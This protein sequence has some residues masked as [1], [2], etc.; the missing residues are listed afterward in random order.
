MLITIYCPLA[1]WNESNSSWVSF[2]FFLVC[3]YTHNYRR[4]WSDSQKKRF[5]GENFSFFVC[6]VV[7]VSRR[8]AK[9]QECRDQTIWRDRTINLSGQRFN[10][11]SCSCSTAQMP[12]TVVNVVLFIST[13]KMF[14]ILN[15]NKNGRNEMK[16]KSTTN[17]DDDQ[18]THLTFL[19]FLNLNENLSVSPMNYCRRRR[20]FWLSIR[21]ITKDIS[22]FHFVFQLVQTCA[23]ALFVFFYYLNLFFKFLKMTS[24]DQ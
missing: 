13:K 2:L 11:D 18:S 23:A 12:K 1:P 8:G 17:T 4:W 19:G 21:R 15:N 3:V 9:G 22:Q 6:V 7:I 5:F 10:D 16:K 24:L 14:L 20:V